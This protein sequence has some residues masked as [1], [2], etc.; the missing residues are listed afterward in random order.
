[1]G[2][3]TGGNKNVSEYLKITGTDSAQNVVLVLFDFGKYQ[4]DLQFESISFV[5]TL[6]REFS[7]FLG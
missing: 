7:D 1:M 2:A 3:L 4:E 5:N 6:V